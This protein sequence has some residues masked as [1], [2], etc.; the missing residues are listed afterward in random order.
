MRLGMNSRMNNN[1]ISGMGNDTRDEMKVNKFRIR[2]KMK[3]KSMKGSIKGKMKGATMNG[4]FKV[5]SEFDLKG[6]EASITNCGVTAIEVKRSDIKY[7]I[8]KQTGTR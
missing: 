1:T 7:T 3:T 8:V 2:G 5:I 6:A 4:K